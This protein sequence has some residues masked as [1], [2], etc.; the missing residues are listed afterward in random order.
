MGGAGARARRRQATPR[1]AR[2]RGYE[3]GEPW[4]SPPTPTQHVRII[5]CRHSHPPPTR[6]AVT[7]ATAAAVAAAGSQP[8]HPHA[9]VRVCAR[10]CARGG[11][12]GEHGAQ[13]RPH[14][15]STPLLPATRQEAG[16]GRG[17]RGGRGGAHSATPGMR[18]CT[19][20]HTTAHASARVWGSHFHG[21]R[22]ECPTT[23]ARHS[24]CLTMC[25]TAAATC[26]LAS[27]GVQPPRRGRSTKWGGTWAAF[28]TDRH[29]CFHAP[30]AQSPCPACGPPRPAPGR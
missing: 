14:A 8:A 29:V 9:H 22:V 19:R 7:A 26:P 30:G 24:P 20:T 11:R 21:G 23:G 2:E 27:R 18:A 25:S 15:P 4:R 28:H 3:R 5:P 17:E 12:G 10:A 1:C 13:P 16:A 6:H